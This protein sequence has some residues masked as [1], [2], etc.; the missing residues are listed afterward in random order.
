FRVRARDHR[1]DREDSLSHLRGRHLVLRTNLRGRQEDRLARR[2]AGPLLHPQIQFIPMIVRYFFVG[3][4]SALVDWVL[5]AALAKGLGVPWFPAATTSFV[6][7]TA[8]NYGLSIRHVFRTGARFGRRHEVALVFLV[9]AVG[10][11]VNQLC[12]WALI[13]V[14]HW[15]L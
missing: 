9:S 2:P 7:A 4:A 5:F 3:A 10:L 13:D 8:V 12:M 15:S 1:E 14:A 6:A 11:T